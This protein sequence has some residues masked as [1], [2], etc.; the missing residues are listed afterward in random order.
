[1]TKN[2]QKK[3]NRALNF[4]MNNIDAE[5]FLTIPDTNFAVNIWKNLQDRFNQ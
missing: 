3:N 4:L 5:D 2:E 1:M